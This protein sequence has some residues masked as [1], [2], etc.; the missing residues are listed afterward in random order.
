MVLKVKV[1][2]TKD[3]TIHIKDKDGN[4][5]DLTDTAV[6]ATARLKIWKNNETATPRLNS[7]SIT[8]NTRAS[9]IMKF[10]PTST[11]FTASDIGQAW[12]YEIEFFASGGSLSDETV[13]GEIE[14]EPSA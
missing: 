11:L 3:W 14:L 6:Y 8:Y 12:F 2:S 4:T 13:T 7:T 10:S 1:G 9:G 5:K